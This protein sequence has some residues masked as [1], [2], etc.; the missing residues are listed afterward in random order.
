MYLSSSFLALC[1]LIATILPKTHA[2][3]S[4]KLKPRQDKLKFRSYTALGDSFAAGVGAGPPAPQD[5]GD[6]RRRTGS[7]AFQFAEK[8]KPDEFHFNACSGFQID[9][10][11]DIQ[12]NSDQS[13]FAFPDLVT[14]SIGGNDGASFFGLAEY[15]I[16]NP[17]WGLISWGV[18]Q[19]KLRDAQATYEGLQPN[20]ERVITAAL[21]HNLGENDRRIVA[22][23]GYPIF[24]NVDNGILKAPQCANNLRPRRQS[25][26]D[27]AGTLNGAIIKAVDAVNANND[28]PKGAGSKAVFVPVNDNFDGHRFCESPDSP[29]IIGGPRAAGNQEPGPIYIAYLHPT[30][31]GQQAFVRKLE[32]VLE[33]EV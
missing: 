29:W 27:V 11:I 2:L 26:N 16:Y 18:C 32:E 14:L 5:L 7:Y 23:M 30:E 24:Y 8:H 12:I 10:T 15:C 28:V 31:E 22:V 20:L 21:T 25:I 19:A 4:Q 6:C 9:N 13:D 1:G 17:F 3:P 33:R